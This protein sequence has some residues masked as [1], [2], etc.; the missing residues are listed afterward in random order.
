MNE[1]KTKNKST[2]DESVIFPT[3]AR[4]DPDVMNFFIFYF[5]HFFFLL[6]FFFSSA[7]FFPPFLWF[8]FVRFFFFAF[9]FVLFLSSGECAC[10]KCPRTDR[11]EMTSPQVIGYV[12]SPRSKKKWKM[13][14]KKK[15]KKKKKRERERTEEIVC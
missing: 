5:F 1:K 14:K 6:V 15:K 4:A 11:T 7:L 2:G 12:R 3:N 8:L 9:V 13:K 10:R